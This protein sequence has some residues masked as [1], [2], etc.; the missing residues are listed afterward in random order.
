MNRVLVGL[1]AVLVVAGLLWPWHQEDA[2]DSSARGYRDRSAGVQVLLSDYDDVDFE[3]I[4]VY[5]G[6]GGIAVLRFPSFF[7]GSLG[8]MV[9]A[10]RRGTAQS[11]RLYAIA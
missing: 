6:V 11:W 2:L 10:V 9:C 1:G 7:G 3:C 5:C 8:A 4:A